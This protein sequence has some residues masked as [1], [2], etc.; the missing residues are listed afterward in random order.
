MKCEVATMCVSF[1][2]RG[3]PTYTDVI[4]YKPLYGI[5]VVEAN[6]FNFATLNVF[7]QDVLDVLDKLLVKWK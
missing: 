3:E 6:W 1:L 2:D 7:H 5:K 4:V